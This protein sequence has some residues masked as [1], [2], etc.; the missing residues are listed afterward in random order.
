[1]DNS[2][3]IDSPELVSAEVTAGQ[4]TRKVLLLQIF[5]Q[6][7]TV[8]GAMIL[9]RLLDAGPFGLW[10]MVFPLMMLPRM[11]AT[12]GVSV[13]AVQKEHL[14]EEQKSALFWV[15]L[16]L[17]AFAGLITGLLGHLFSWLYG[18]P[19][20]AWICWAFAGT[21]VVEASSLTHQTLLQRELKI[22]RIAGI[23]LLGQAIAVSV[24]IYTGYQLGEDVIAYGIVALIAMEYA[25]MV[26]NALGLWLAAGWRPGRFRT[27]E[28]TGL[29]RFGGYY[30]CSSLV[31]YLGQNLDKVLLA[32]VI[33]ST[34]SGQR[35]MGMYSA[36][37]H[38]MMKPV[39]FVT[40][41][42]TSVM[43]PSLSRSRG[44][45]EEYRRLAEGFY[46]FTATLLLPAGV[47][48]LVV[49]PDVVPLLGGAKWDPATGMLFGL[50]PAVCVHGLIN[51]SG[52]LLASA[53]QAR[54]LLCA[55]LVLLL[56]QAQAYAA[57]YFFG[58]HFGRQFGVTAEHA[59]AVG[60]AVSYSAVL[61]MVSIPYL[62]FCYRS[63][64]MQMGS[65]IYQCLRLLGFAFLMGVGVWF[66]RGQLS[67]LYPAVRLIICVAAGA[68]MY[69]LLAWSA[70]QQNVWPFIRRSG[71]RGSQT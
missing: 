12:L 65:T 62:L 51:I 9:F 1:M 54:R 14:S 35:M 60:I 21:S 20:L 50:A 39:Y 22:G 49:S 34:R 19:E 38:L 4:E 56:I 70:L 3:D 45:R 17:G 44:K 13:A 25:E 32:A 23:K 26:I 59:T 64:E 36:M 18:V 69:A 7:V 67:G 5:R 40:D 10:G 24:G 30:S 28:I 15:T 52:S 58:H 29:L 6:I 11:A 55:S 71:I 16:L 53:G 48:L 41:P 66:V 37:Y 42:V 31:F 47:G 68:G 27:K 61:L 57:G 33:G 8:V 43:L 46:L 63:V 2:A